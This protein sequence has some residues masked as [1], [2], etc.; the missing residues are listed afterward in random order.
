MQDANAESMRQRQ[1]LVKYLEGNPQDLGLSSILKVG[2]VQHCAALC[3]HC[4]SLD[5]RR[6]RSARAPAHTMPN[7]RGA[8]L[9]R[10]KDSSSTL[11]TRC[12]AVL[13]PFSSA[14]LKA[15]RVLHPHFSL[16]S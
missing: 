13:E 6:P 11:P 2:A 7:A 5:T 14:R 9:S 12:R 1:I 4:A 16:R 15:V 10:G 3:I 8:L